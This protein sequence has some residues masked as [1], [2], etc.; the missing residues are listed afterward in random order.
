[1]KA[2]LLLPFVLAAGVAHAETISCKKDNSSSTVPPAYQLKELSVYRA[3]IAPGSD[4]TILWNKTL[5]GMAQLSHE[6]RQFYLPD[7]S[8]LYK[9]FPTNDKQF[10]LTVKPRTDGVLGGKLVLTPARNPSVFE[11]LVCEGEEL[12]KMPKFCKD[13]GKKDLQKLMIGAVKQGDDHG[14]EQALLCGADANIK[15]SAGCPLLV[16]AVDPSCGSHGIGSVGDLNPEAEVIFNRL[17]DGG[18]IIDGRDPKTQETSLHKAARQNLPNLVE[19]LVSLE[20]DVNA[21]DI[22]GY[23]PIMRVAETGDLELIK[24]FMDGNPNL[25]LKNKAGLTALDIAKKGGFKRLYALLSPNKTTYVL[26]GKPTRDGCEPDEIRVKLNEPAVI[27]LDAKDLPMMRV[28]SQSLG[29]DV[30]A[31]PNTQ[32]RQ[33]I[34]PS[35]KGEFPFTCGLHGALEQTNGKIIVE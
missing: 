19:S 2:A 35:K 22:S 33:I 3:E 31:E 30:M 32:S 9:S 28:T 23:T 1:M 21:Q 8:I 29:L 25:E 5:I 15:T 11:N 12:P 26:T 14:V 24:M 18:A 10:A 6:L 13:E 7:G 34:L 20:A 17:A 4:E 16:A 27:V